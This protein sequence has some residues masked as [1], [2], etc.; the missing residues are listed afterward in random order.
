[1][2]VTEKGQ[3]TIPLEIRRSLGIEPGTEVEFILE[4][5]SV[6]LRRVAHAEAV[7]EQLQKYAG[8]ADSGLSTEEILSLTRQ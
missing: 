4:D 6:R 7:R 3:V 2:R 8:T 1:M 5:D